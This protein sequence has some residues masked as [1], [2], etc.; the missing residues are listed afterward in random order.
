MVA[1]R[2]NVGRSLVRAFNGAGH[3]ARLVPSREALPALEEGIVFLA[4]PDAAVAQVARRMARSNSAEA[5]GFVHVSGA[6]G[7]DALAPL[8]G[9][10]PTGS[11]HPLQ[12]FPAPRP[13]DA[14]RG[15]TVAVD[16]TTTSLERRLAQLARDLG[17]LPRHVGDEQRVRYHAAA[18]FASNYLIAVVDEGVH[19]LMAAGWSRQEA[20]QALLPLV[21][22]VVRNM[23]G[24][25]VREA[26]TGPIKRGDADTVAR[27]LAALRGKESD[28]YRMLGLVTLEIAKEAGLEPG[29]VRRT[30]RALTRNVA[31]TR[32]R[33]RT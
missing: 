10:H 20:E 24:A 28:L 11:F 4:V 15:V 16:A 14:F 29:A 32:R 27:H 8:A 12:S 7:L 33:G 5:V 21:E 19:V 31:A 17:G 18:V 1:G 6:L 23:R 9:R 22:G 30:S 13:P 2:G 3:R 26:L 25:G